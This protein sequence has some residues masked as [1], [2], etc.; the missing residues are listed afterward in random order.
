MPQDHGLWPGIRVDQ[1]LRAVCKDDTL[2]EHWLRALDL[3]EL[4]DRVPQTLS[5]GERAR[6]ALARALCTPAPT[7]LLDEP[8]SAIDPE[9]SLAYWDAI[10]EHALAER[11]FLF[12]AAH[13]PA[14]VLRA[15]GHALCLR[16]GQMAWH[17]PVD[18]LYHHPASESLMHR[19][20]AGTWFTEAEALDWLGSLHPG[21]RRPAQLEIQECAD[22]PLV[23]HRADPLGS[24]TRNHVKNIF[25]DSEKIFWTLGGPPTP[26]GTRGRIM[27]RA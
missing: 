10:L 21:C 8:L 3:Y 14:Q 27:A 11:R 4:R 18:E 16:E 7:L 6:C 19:L 9:R 25:R 1:H 26:P 24:E 23:L 13:D 5:V 15:G 22:G 17:G 12:Y 20:G 2:R